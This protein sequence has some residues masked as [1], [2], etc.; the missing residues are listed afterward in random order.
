VLV[1][2]PLTGNQARSYPLAAQLADVSVPLRSIGIY[3]EG[4]QDNFTEA[5]GTRFYKHTNLDAPTMD[6]AS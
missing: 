3:E 4:L 6:F 2:D 1:G 5:P